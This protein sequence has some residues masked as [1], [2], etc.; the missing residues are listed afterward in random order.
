MPRPISRIG[1]DLVGAGGTMTLG[2]P[3]VFINNIPVALTGT[4]VTPHVQGTI[5]HPAAVVIGT[6][7]K[8]FIN[9]VPFIRMGDIAT[10]TDP[11]LSGAPNVF[12]EL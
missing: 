6:T 7:V 4:P 5:P 10:C 1:V 9:G 3:N 8:T 12:A 11:V 2:S